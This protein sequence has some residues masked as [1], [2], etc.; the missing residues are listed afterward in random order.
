MNLTWLQLELT[1][2]WLLLLVVLALRV[3]GWSY[4]RGLTDFARWQRLASLLA[5]TAIVVLL[6]AALCGLTLLKPSKDL[7]VVFAIDDSLS[8]GDEARP[9]V[10]RFLQ[11]ASAAAGK[12]KVAYL[13]FAAEP[14]PVVG[15]LAAPVTLNKQGTNIA[16]ALEVA[17]AAIPPASVPRIVVL[18]DGNQTAGDA[19]K[20]ALCYGPPGSPVP[21]QT[22]ADPELQV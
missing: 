15:D 13:R 5:R 7:F 21:L 3:L 17:A 10:D 1:Q 22:R 4:Y 14:G 8:V 20:A 18:S 6:V 2:P 9:E 19:L 11:Q 16:A 12:N